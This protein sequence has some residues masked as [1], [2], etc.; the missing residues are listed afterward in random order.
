MR[1]LLFITVCGLMGVTTAQAQPLLKTHVETGE[2]EGVLEGTDLACY[3]A[4]P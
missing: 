2:V 4:I 1:K 3:Y